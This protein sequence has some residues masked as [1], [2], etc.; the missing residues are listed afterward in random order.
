[1]V[2]VDEHPGMAVR[3]SELMPFQLDGTTEAFMTADGA[4]DYLNELVDKS[5]TAVNNQVS[6]RCMYSSFTTY[7]ENAYAWLAQNRKLTSE[8]HKIPT[9]YPHIK[10]LSTSVVLP[11]ACGEELCVQHTSCE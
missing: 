10:N 7:H 5:A 4:R 6:H 8:Y 9:G 2:L 3:Q 1:M 11:E